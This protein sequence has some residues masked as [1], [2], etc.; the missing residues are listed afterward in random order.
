MKKMFVAV[1]IVS[2]VA[3]YSM[4]AE[5]KPLKDIDSQALTTDT[6]VT[7]K[8]TGD[9][10]TAMAWWIP[11]EFWES[12]FSR[13]ATTSAF[14]KKA[15][16]DALSGVSLLAVVQADMTAV[17]GFE[18]YSKEEIEQSMTISYSDA[19]GQQRRLSLLQTIDPDL[20][21]ILGVFKPVLG[22]A[23][24]NLGNNMHFYVLSDRSKST[25]RLLDPYRNGQINIRLARRDKVLMDA[26]IQLPLDALFV[27]RKCPN[28][29]NAHISW[30]YC[31]WT[32]KQLEE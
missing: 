14:D 17:G 30:R 7:P 21:V 8:G 27:P 6:Q 15:M 18:F 24:G 19:D 1:M 25:P 5:K 4:A 11:I 23:M 22:A 29:K 16:L 32:G 10:H 26:S 13:D 31:P 9:Q 3:T 2:M 12:L 28:G 20:A